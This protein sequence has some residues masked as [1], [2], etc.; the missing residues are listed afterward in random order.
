MNP[1]VPFSI[2]AARLA[3]ALLSLGSALFVLPAHA[4]TF[5][6]AASSKPNTSANANTLYYRMT[7]PIVVGDAAKLQGILNEKKAEAGKT[8]IWLHMDARGG[9]LE[10]A[11]R[12]GRLLR[13]Y[14]AYT[15]HGQCVGSCVYAF[16]GGNTR[17][18]T[19]HKPQ[20][21]MSSDP[22]DMTGLWVYEPYV[23]AKV[24]PMAASNPTIAQAL[25]NVKDYT[26]EMTG[27]TKF[28]DSTIQ[29]PHT[30]PIRM[31]R[32]DAFGMNVCSP[33]ANGGK[34]TKSVPAGQKPPGW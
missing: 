10:E 28:Y 20:P 7:G 8:N 25:K 4:A 26:V 2:R 33:E 29:V 19:P 17:L 6:A 13:K 1:R 24:L 23:M 18:Y 30:K 31:I 34:T 15:S 11:F 12:I 32:S 27:K 14:K 3:L 16:M 22:L 9:D 5:T 21:E